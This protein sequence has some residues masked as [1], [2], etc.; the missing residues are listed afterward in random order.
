MRTITIANQKGGV[1]KSTTSVNVAR[2]LARA[3]RTVLLIDLDSQ[4]NASFAVLG[5]PIPDE[6]PTIYDLMR[7]DTALPTVL[8]ATQQDRLA[9]LPSNINL[10]AAEVEFPAQPG[11]SALLR[12]QLEPVYDQYDYIIID[13]PPSL[14]ILT[15]NA[16]AAST[17][18]LVPVAPSAFS[19]SGLLKLRDTVEQV[20]R[21]VQ[22]QLRITGILLTLV[23]RTNVARDIQEGLEQRFPNLL[24]RTRVRRNVKVEE[25]HSRPEGLFEYAP[26]SIGAQ[27]YGQL[28]EELIAHE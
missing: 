18:V 21:R 10:A 23:E 20:R 28:V 11:S 16:L 6:E 5:Q 24:L 8:R 7:G 17:E 4:G 1:A 19:L 25:A 14:G 26:D 12:E 3:G 13:T 15:I 27:D 2:G 22:K 9:V